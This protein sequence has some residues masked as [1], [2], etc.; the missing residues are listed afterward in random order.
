MIVAIRDDV[1][2]SRNQECITAPSA[3]AVIG[4]S[5]RGAD[6]Y[7]YLLRKL[8]QSDSIDDWKKELNYFTRR[9]ILEPLGDFMV[10]SPAPV[11]VALF[12]QWLEE[13]PPDDVVEFAQGLADVGLLEP[14]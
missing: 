10:V 7:P 13:T 8:L 11:A 14:F 6:Q 5:G 3:V 9:R 12:S 1:R 2:H 4:I